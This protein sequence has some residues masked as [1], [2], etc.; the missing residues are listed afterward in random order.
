[1]NKINI[2]IPMAGE[3][4]RFRTENF[5]LPKPFIPIDGKPMIQWVFENL[6]APNINTNFICVIRSE[7]DTAFNIKEHLEALDSRVQVVYADA[8]TDG[9]ACTCLLAKHLIEDDTPLLIANSDQFVEWDASEFYAVALSSGRDGTVLCFHHPRELND[10]KWSYAKLDQNENITDI[11]EKKVISEH[12]TV[13]LYF[14]NKGSDF[15]RCAEKMISR[16]ILVNGEFYVAPVYNE[17]VN[18]GSAYK[19]HHC[20]K[21]WGLGTPADV[22]QFEIAYLGKARTSILESTYH[23][24]QA[25]NQKSLTKLQALFSPDMILTDGNG[26]FEGRKSSLQ[27]ISSLFDSAPIGEF[28]L[29]VERLFVDGQ[30]T[31]FEFNSVIQGRKV[32]GV[33]VI[34][35]SADPLMKELRAYVIFL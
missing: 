10:T 22:I 27:Y 20:D 23:Y 7:H 15:V 32:K 14:W 24:V 4:S 25:F 29:T 30:V 35:W 13:G 16:S 3:G 12:A 34:T 8:L 26:R 11:Q 5:R 1:M 2:L 19:V 17:G 18:D 9:A 33:D 21:M 31:V 6:S 28:A